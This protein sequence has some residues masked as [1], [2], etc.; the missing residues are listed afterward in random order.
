MVKTPNHPT[1][2]RVIKQTN[3]VKTT[4]TKTTQKKTKPD[5]TKKNLS[6]E[7]SAE[8]S[9][10]VEMID[11]SENTENNKNTSNT[12]TKTTATNLKDPQSHS[13]H[14]NDDNSQMSTNSDETNKATNM[15]TTTTSPNNPFQLLDPNARAFT[16]ASQIETGK[17]TELMDQSNKNGS[18]KIIKRNY[19]GLYSLK[20][21][22]HDNK[23]AA[24]E[25]KR[26]LQEWF[27][28]LK[29][30]DTSV[31]IY[32]WKNDTKSRAITKTTD[33]TNKVAPMKHFFHTIRP[34]SSK[35]F[36][37]C[38]V[39]LGHDGPASE[40]DE[41]M[42]WWY[43]EK[44]GGIYKKALQYKDSVQVAWLLY[45]HEKV[46]RDLLTEKLGEKCELMWNKKLPMALSWTQIKDGTYN[47]SKKP[48]DPNKTYPYAIHIHCRTKDQEEI[49]ALIKT[50]YKTTQTKFPLMMAFRYVPVIERSSTSHL[51]TKIK[52]LRRIQIDFLCSS[53]H[54]TSWEINTL[55]HK[56]DGLN[57]T[58]REMLMNIKSNEYND[59]VFLSINEDSSGGYNF[60]FPIAYEDKARDFI[61]EFPAYLKYKH[62]DLIK[63]YLT[64][65]AAE[66]LKDATW[67]PKLERVITDEDL[68]LEMI[69]TEAINRSWIKEANEDQLLD[70]PGTTTNEKEIENDASKTASLF[71]FGSNT[72]RDDAS[73][74]TFGTKHQEK[75]TTANEEDESQKS[76]ST[77]STMNSKT[78]IATRMTTVESNMVTMGNT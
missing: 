45:S 60:T 2:S 51:K 48:F 61:T 23:N 34:R 68:E 57:E 67:D 44:K 58:L 72:N 22:T 21:P 65:S 70:E 6:K 36:M 53:M 10:D 52:R 76:A 42:E 55:D 5:K 25:M 73:V 66:R 56:T 69:E 41:G 8:A 43:K 30:V 29:E 64:A 46:D 75:E 54:A 13:N 26:A 11:V 19:E 7:M 16:P 39:H 37:W 38:S 71:T 17:D 20:L 3:A 4:T 15:D 50:I 62:G 24:D 59:Y 32:N 1:T 40:L 9:K 78:T 18:S 14:H 74:S 49:R 35:G 27:K 77:I 63:K 12:S 33:I 47:T 28:E 31:V